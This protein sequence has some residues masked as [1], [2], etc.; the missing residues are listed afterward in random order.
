MDGKQAS[1]LDK[2]F[3]EMLA[4]LCPELPLAEMTSVQKIRTIVFYVEETQGK[5]VL[6]A[7]LGSHLTG[8]TPSPS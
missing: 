5:K 7:A 2:L 8:A 1:E 6:E 3:D 4:I